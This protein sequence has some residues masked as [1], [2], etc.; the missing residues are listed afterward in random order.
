[1]TDEQWN[2]IK[3]LLMQALQVFY[4]VLTLTYF[5]SLKDKHENLK[6]YQELVRI[7]AIKVNLPALIYL[8]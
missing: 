6:A 3:P 2:K 7:G 1:M 5:Q 8:A 4:F